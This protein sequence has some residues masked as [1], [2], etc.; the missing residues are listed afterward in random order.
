LHGLVKVQKSLMDSGVDEEIIVKQEIEIPECTNDGDL[1]SS[2]S[3]ETVDLKPNL[4]TLEI[5]SKN[6]AFQ[7]YKPLTILTN[8]QRGNVKTLCRDP[9]PAHPLTFQERAAKGSLVEDDINDSNVNSLD[10]D[11]LTALMWATFHGKLSTVEL[12]LNKG[13]DV[14]STGPDGQTA[15]MFA[16]A[17]GH[18]DT[19]NHLLSCGADIE[20]EDDFGNTPLMHAAHYNQPQSINILLSHGA[21]LTKPNFIGDNSYDIAFRRGH[22]AS[23]YAIEV[24]LKKILESN[25]A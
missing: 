11:G 10:S 19:L 25:A 1:G 2:S 16:S 3:P 9:A 5:G 21:S 17:K 15:L 18:T 13:A 7:P 24:H 6:S 20:L 22:K 23:Q 14:N 12:L 4:Q 8:L